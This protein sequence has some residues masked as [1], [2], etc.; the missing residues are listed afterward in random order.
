MR[1]LR[2]TAY[3]LT[4]AEH[5]RLGGFDGLEPAAGDGLV[6]PAPLAVG[7]VATDPVD[8]SAVAV[9]V[10]PC[11]AT[12]WLRSNGEL[13]LAHKGHR[14]VLGILPGGPAT[15]LVVGDSGIWLAG[16]GGLVLYDR[17]LL[18]PLDEIAAPGVVAIAGDGRDGAWMLAAPP[19][20]PASWRRLDRHGSPVGGP[21]AC[22]DDAV[23]VAGAG[24][25]DGRVLV[26]LDRRGR[27]WAFE[28]AAARWRRLLDLAALACGFGP[29]HLAVDW[30]GRVHLI[31]EVRGECWTIGRDGERIAWTMLALPAPISGVAG[32]RDLV[33]VATAE[34]VLALGRREEAAAAGAATAREARFLTPTLVSP[35]AERQGW[36]RADV[37]ADLPLG[38]TLAV[39]VA[40]SDD[41]ALRR[42]V[43]AILAD[44]TAPPAVRLARA[45][46]LLPFDDAAAAVLTSDDDPSGEGR[47]NVHLQDV[48]KT[49][50]W[51]ELGLHAPPGSA[52]P[53]LRSL[54]VRY[55]SRTWVEDL[56][57][58]YGED[59]RAAQQLR[60]F[61][62]VF[63]TVFDGLEARIEALPTLFDPAETETAAWLDVT[64]HRLGLAMPADLPA[65]AKRRLLV[66]APDLLRGRGTLAALVS[67]LEAATGARVRAVDPAQGPPPWVPGLRD[68]GTAARLGSGSLLTRRT[69]PDFRMNGGARLA[70]TALGRGRVDPREQMT[71]RSGSVLILIAAPPA[72]RRTLMPAIEA[73]LDRFLPA[74]CRCR[75]AFAA[76]DATAGRHLD[77]DAVLAGEAWAELGGTAVVGHAALAAPRGG[78]GIDAR[79]DGT[80]RLT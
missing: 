76:D 16:A 34:G 36:Y 56:P 60:R 11:G 72:R 53:A 57:R 68:A 37:E 17:R 25:C 8:R 27:L 38:T 46:G 70:R 62:A 28:T 26:L 44:Q 75:L 59:P 54:T 77:D 39:R 29:R 65:E 73:V 64:L 4:G 80:S 12:L 55:P 66:A 15:G 7:E 69:T 21:I 79:L 14:L 9:A 31:D 13:V 71:V 45:R 22:P 51:L 2:D 19:D 41:E 1:A 43:D 18:Q 33:L 30:A 78:L 6:V 32:G 48:Q 40:A 50:L 74:N 67:A 10:D 23:P 52:G 24:S 5:W 61:L 49:Y 58:I 42:R 47:F 3:R 20:G 35:R 63:E